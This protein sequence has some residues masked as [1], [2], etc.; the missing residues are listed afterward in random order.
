VT[1]WVELKPE[2][3]ER[4]GGADGAGEGSGMAVVQSFKIPKIT[5]TAKT[6]VE[7]VFPTAQELPE[8]LLKFYIHFSAPMSRGQAYRRIRLLDEEGDT[9]ELPFLELQQELWDVEGSRFTLF[10]DPGRI[11]RGLLPNQQVGLP[12]RAGHTYT[13]WIDR[14]W[15]DATGQPLEKEFRKRFRVRQADR[16]SPSVS[17][18]QFTAPKEGAISALTVRFPESLEHALLMRLV[19]IVDPQGDVLDGNVIVASDE[20]C[21]RFEPKHPWGAGTHTLRVSTL[22]EDLVGNSIERPFEVELEDGVVSEEAG[23]VE[24]KFEIEKR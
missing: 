23:W 17:T 1:Y 5:T 10:F 19:E 15:P 20:T 7:H 14:G 11:K 22:L 18:W 8:N 16:R 6:F 24:V 4:D 21:W 2:A 13:L 9:V 12:L 3:A